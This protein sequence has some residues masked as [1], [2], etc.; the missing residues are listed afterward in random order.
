MNKIQRIIAGL[1][2]ALSLAALPALAAETSPS[3]PAAPPE[4]T[5]SAPALA[6]QPGT[7]PA[8][9][10]QAPG[11]APRVEL[12]PRPLRLGWPATS[13]GAPRVCDR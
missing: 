3:T 6:S 1:V 9:P 5:P 10:R 8:P 11:Q 7:K 2:L 12:Q 13:Y 4:Q